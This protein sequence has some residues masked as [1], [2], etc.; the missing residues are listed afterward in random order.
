MRL[1]AAALSLVLLA[2]VSYAQRGD[3]GSGTFIGGPKYK[4]DKAPTSRALKGT[5]TDDSG[6]PIE[7]ALVTLTNES[8]NERWTFI[9]K[10]DGRFNFDD[11][12]FTIDYDV[13]ARYGDSHSDTKKLSQ[14]DR[15]PNI[16]RV[17]EIHPPANSDTKSTAAATSK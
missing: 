14:Y 11:L 17:L 5:V 3:P 6:K 7:R 12:S 8:T 2:G 1:V 4:K 16:V 15:T 10:K 9:T 13:S